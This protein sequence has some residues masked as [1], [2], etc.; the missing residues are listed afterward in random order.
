MAW[1]K[2]ARQTLFFGLC[3]TLLH[4]VI[5]QTYSYGASGY[6]NGRYVYGDIDAYRGSRDV[7]GYIYDSSGNAKYFSGEWVR[8]GVVEGTDEDGNYVELEVD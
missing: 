7:D 2:L 3:L 1:W 6:S 5:A 4:P 8:N